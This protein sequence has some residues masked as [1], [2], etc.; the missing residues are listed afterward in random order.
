MPD[1]KLVA[2]CPHCGNTAPQRLLLAQ[3]YQG[4]WY[5][6]E[7][8]E[9]NDDDE[10]PVSTNFVA[11]CETCGDIL[12]YHDAIG[13]FGPA[14]FTSADLLW[15]KFVL[16]DSV[17]SSV[18]K[19]YEEAARI[20]HV[21]PNAFATQIRR[22]L[23]AICDDRGAKD[24]HLQQRLKGLVSQGAIPPTLAEM[25]DALRLIG[26][27]GAHMSDEGVKPIQVMAIDDFFRAIVEYVYIAPRKLKDFLES[28]KELK[29]KTR[30]H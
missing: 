18:R 12:L 20:K 14:E 16:P 17:P 29:R 28:S 7:S 5:S 15:P 21:A 9:Q 4:T 19:C 27:T 22:A 8:G 25:S 30:R 11:V 10:I 13:D 3:Q 1:Q 2:F 6:T 26:N 23:E 24:G